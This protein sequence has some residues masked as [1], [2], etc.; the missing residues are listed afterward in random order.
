MDKSARRS[1][2]DSPIRMYKS[3]PDVHPRSK[4]LVVL[5]PQELALHCGP[6]Q[7]K[8][9][10]TSRHVFLTE[11]LPKSNLQQRH[12]GNDGSSVSA[13]RQQ[14]LWFLGESLR[15]SPAST[16]NPLCHLQ[17][18]LVFLSKHIPVSL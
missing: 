6:Q 12:R 4:S 17:N 10:T 3:V 7:K 14:A 13:R 11:P 5:W 16:T 18:K 1:S 8:Q 9:A 2:R 15:E